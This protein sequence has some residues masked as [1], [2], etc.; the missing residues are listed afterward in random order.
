MII[1]VALHPD[2]QYGATLFAPALI[3]DAV[4]AAVTFVG[5]TPAV[6]VHPARDVF[7]ILG[8]RVFATVE[9]AR[10]ARKADPV[11]YEIRL[12]RY[13]GGM[14]ATEKRLRADGYQEMGRAK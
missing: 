3:D 7:V 14:K 13:Y 9:P 12:A 4:P 2:R 8:R 1:T 6:F 11:L 5:G 10:K